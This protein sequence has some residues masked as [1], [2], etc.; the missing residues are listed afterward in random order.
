MG[1]GLQDFLVLLHDEE[2]RVEAEEVAVGVY[3]RFISFASLLCARKYLRGSFFTVA[4]L[5]HSIASDQSSARQVMC[6]G[7]VHV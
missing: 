3:E 4:D 6:H 7:G 5:A 1:P 2:I